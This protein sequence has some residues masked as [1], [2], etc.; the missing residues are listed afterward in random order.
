MNVLHFC[1]VSAMCCPSYFKTDLNMLKTTVSQCL[2]LCLFSLCFG[3]E[4]TTPHQWFLV[5]PNCQVFGT[6]FVKLIFSSLVKYFEI[7]KKKKSRKMDEN[8]EKKSQKKKCT[9][10]PNCEQTQPL[11]GNEL[12]NKPHLPV[13]FLKIK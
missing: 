5:L 6:G 2:V 4:Y 13:A 12:K 3:S 1:F 7:E 11:A 10:M 9:G 8:F